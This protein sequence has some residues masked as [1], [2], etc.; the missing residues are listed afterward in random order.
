ML[1]DFHK[2]LKCI[3][4]GVPVLFRKPLALNVNIS[5]RNTMH[6]LILYFG[7]RLWIIANKLLKQS[8]F[9][10]MVPKWEIHSIKAN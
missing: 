3:F 2:S 7:T 10:K 9:L 6:F 5:R 1:T 8:N 4:A